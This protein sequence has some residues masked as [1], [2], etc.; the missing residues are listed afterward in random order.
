MKEKNKNTDAE[1]TEMGNLDKD[2]PNSDIVQAQQTKWRLSSFAK[3]LI[4]GIVVAISS[5]LG[6]YFVSDIQSQL[7]SYRENRYEI[8]NKSNKA[9]LEV[10]IN[11]ESIR[12][13]CKKY[14]Q[15]PPASDLENLLEKQ[16]QLS[17]DF[18][19][20][21]PNTG[22]YFGSEVNSEVA[23][24]FQWS[25]SQS[26]ITNCV[27]VASEEEADNI[28]KKLFI[29]LSRSIYNDFIINP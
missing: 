9:S 15:N 2:I 8:F 7:N 14:N 26:K 11:L 25:L 13:L 19:R 10:K 28:Q 20:T 18:L 16:S 27:N 4:V 23:S 1:R 3:G 6:G 22:F 21:T 24:F 17:Y 29:S 5:T 12:S